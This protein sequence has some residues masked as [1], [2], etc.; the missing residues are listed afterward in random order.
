[1]PPKKRTATTTTTT[2]PMT[3]AQ[4]KALVVQGV[5]GALAERD[6]DRSRNGND[7]H[8]S[9]GDER[10]RMHVS[11]ECTYS[12]FL[13][14]QPLNFKGT[15]GSVGH[16]QWLEKIESVFYISNYTTTNQVMT[17]TLHGNALTWW[18]SH[19]KNVTP[20][21][22]YGMTWKA[23]KTMMTNKYCPKGEIKKLEIE[24]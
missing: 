23:L 11:R 6:V 19:V 12:D 22:A 5:A 2:T 18:N 1:M 9:G 7:S 10:R 17:C 20:E 8:D 15:G 16:T 13:K 24:L 3:D 4:L 21:V 14:C